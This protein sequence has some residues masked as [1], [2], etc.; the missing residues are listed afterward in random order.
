MLKAHS[1]LYSVYVCLIVA[2]ICGALLY[3]ATLYNQLNLFY[4]TNENLYI[5]NQSAVNYALGTNFSEESTDQ[6]DTTGVQTNIAKKPFGLLELLIVKSYAHADTI[7]SAHFVGQNNPEKTCIYISSISKPITYSGQ[8]KLIGNKTLPSPTINSDYI[9]NSINSLTSTGTVSISEGLLPEVNSN[10]KKTIT[11][12]FTKLQ[13]LKSVVRTQ[14]SIYFN[15]FLNETI[16]IEL[17]S[18]IIDNIIIKGNFIL[19]SKDSIQVRRNAVLEDVILKS[20]T[21]TFAEGFKGNVQAFSTEKLTLQKSVELG[22]PSVVCLYNKSSEKSEIV[23]GEKSKIFGA[24][25]LFGNEINSIDNNS[26]TLSK[27]TFLLGSVY[28][29]GKIMLGGKVYGS[30]Y[31]NRVFHRTKSASYENCIVDAEIDV[32][33]KPLYFISIPILENKNKSNG[34]YKKV[35]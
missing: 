18:S 12:P 30:V 16:E 11:A 32:S 31:T 27:D 33:R 1:L 9:N 3:F 14:D 24:I 13:S 4:N 23:V 19:Y 26:I 29:T 35:L 5:Q 17:P 20:P 6:I 28:C 8:V 21:I 7:T 34:I 22:Y 2:I 10:F 15:S 25:V